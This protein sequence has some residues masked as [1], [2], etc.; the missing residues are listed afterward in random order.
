MKSVITNPTAMNDQVPINARCQNANPPAPST[1]DRG[2][3]HMAR[4]EAS[5]DLPTVRNYCVI[6]RVGVKY[7]HYRA[8][9]P[10]RHADIS[11][12]RK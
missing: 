8:R 7:R 2:L 9:D 1:V 6:H 4:A 3:R 11:L 10:F 5:D 12:S